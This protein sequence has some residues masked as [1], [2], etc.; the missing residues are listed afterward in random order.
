MD[1]YDF[2]TSKEDV[3]ENIKTLYGYL[4]NPDDAETYKWATGILKNGRIYVVEVIDSKLYFAPS[5]FVG[6]KKNTADKHRENHGDGNQTNDK[7]VEYYQKVQDERL[8]AAFQSVLEQ[9]DLSSGDKKYWIPKD[10]TIEQLLSSSETQQKQYWI[11][12]VTSDE[13][14]D[15][16]LSNNV[17]VT[18]Q[19]YGHQKSSAVS[20]LLGCVR[21]VKAGD[22]I[23][24]TYGSEIYAYG[25]V[26]E[27]P[28]ASDQVSNLQRVIQKN[29]HDYNSG[30]VKFEDNNVFYEDLTKGCDNWG[31]RITVDQW[32]YY[33][34][35]TNV[36]TAGMLKEI[37]MG[38]TTM[39]LIGIT[40]KYGKKKVKELKEQFENKHMFIS[41]TAKLLQS[42]HNIILQGAPGTGKTYNTAAIALAAL[43]VTDVDLN[44]HKA[45]MKRYDSLLGD[46][47]FFTTFHQSLDYED[48]V[49]GLKPHVQT[50]ADGNSIGVTY[51]PEDGIFKRACNAVQTDQSKDIVECID[52]YLQKIKG[53]QNKREIPTV[54][55]RSSLYVWWKEGNSTV[56]S[57][58]T[59]STS[60]RGEEY[61]PS[62]LNIEKI[63]LQA[64]GKGCENNWQSY[65]Q[66]FIEAVKREYHATTD[67]PVVLIIDEINRGNVS[68][69]FGELITLLESDKRSNGNHPIKVMLPYTKGEFGVPS[70]LYIIG[71]MNTTD[72]STG[73][74]DYAL[75]RRFAFVTL[76]SQDSVIKKYYSDAGNDELG[77]VAVA[78]FDDIKKFIENPKHL[79]GDMSID[80]LMVGHSYFMA[81]SEEELQDKVEFEILPLINEY[82][83]DGIL[84]VK[85]E[86]KKTAFDAWRSLNP[87]QV[88]DED[89][90]EDDDE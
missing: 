11:G 6:Y 59:N 86:E 49:E 85:N 47:I 53:Y 65:A 12:R 1:R 69:I 31:Q 15:V 13:Y 55:G 87:I 34:D 76:K 88:I 10:M 56:S 80:D 41:K 28:L 63:K 5:R 45:V 42:K 29:R 9:Y 48:F 25:N 39:S 23:F 60:S 82:I 90:Q 46:Q 3:V 22:I 70:N 77:S 57:R 36:S 8:D 32:H 67:K 71:T 20:G 19:R 73:T 4:G 14:W 61:T 81:E 38:V 79:C 68:K 35:R 78:L 84:N 50:D 54:T 83:N 30:I 64:L 75:R 66:A 58:S 51:E 40:E 33:S 17:W 18:Q 72:R 37:T 62:P 27:C 7:L 43:D 44:D 74:L 52:D 89:D 26:I 24:L 21:N 2:I 16:A